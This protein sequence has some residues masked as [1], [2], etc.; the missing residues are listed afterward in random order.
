M[1]DTVPEEKDIDLTEVDNGQMLEDT[2]LQEVGNLGHQAN[3]KGPDVLVDNS[4][5]RKASIVDRH[6]QVVVNMLVG[7]EEE[8]P[9]LSE[10]PVRRLEL[11][12]RSFESFRLPIRK[13]WKMCLRVKDSDDLTFKIIKTNSFTIK[14]RVSKTTY[15]WR[16]S[17]WCLQS[18]HDE[19]DRRI[20]V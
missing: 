7:Q 16:P 17:R 6:L 5:A 10:C 12:C 8:K 9:R 15:R 3:R 14:P 19:M 13:F 18:Y 20:H 2:D 11:V 4:V 1:V